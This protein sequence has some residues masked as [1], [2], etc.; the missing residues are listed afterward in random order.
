MAAEREIKFRVDDRSA[1]LARLVDLEAE[2]VNSSQ[3]EDNWVF[4]RGEELRQR[5]CV[6][7]GDRAPT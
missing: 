1:L 4:D 5:R 2:Q 7:P 3:F 6:L